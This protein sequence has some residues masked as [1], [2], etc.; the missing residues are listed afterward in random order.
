MLIRDWQLSRLFQAEESGAGESSSAGAAIEAPVV[1]SSP[2]PEVSVT[3][4]GSLDSDQHETFESYFDSLEEKSKSNETS[5]KDVESTPNTSEAMP[6]SATEDSVAAKRGGDAGDKVVDVQR[7]ALVSL[8]KAYDWSDE[9]LKGFTGEQLQRLIAREEKRAPQLQPQETEA[10][11]G[12]QRQEQVDPFAEYVNNRRAALEAQGHD[13]DFINTEIERDQLLFSGN[14]QL[15][16]QINHERSQHAFQQETAAFDNFLISE[17]APSF[18]DL[19]G[20]KSIRQEGPEQR[21]ARQKV[22]Q[23]YQ[24]LKQVRPNVSGED[25]VR[26]AFTGVFGAQ[27]QHRN[28]VAHA[29]RMKSHS[30]RRMGSPSST[31]PQN[32][33][34]WKGPTAQ[35]PVLVEA[36]QRVTAERRQRV[37]AR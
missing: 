10:E 12:E 32:G 1:D 35:D 16:Q 18:P 24:A 5:T 8:A 20:T 34:E 9:E 37:G 36:M 17:L 3:T 26:Q 2:A 13:E 29:N 28:Q 4:T 22:F 33:V 23:L 21:A 15:Q 30:S 11:P 19:I 31:A 27:I 25:L 6:N 14:Q 7:D